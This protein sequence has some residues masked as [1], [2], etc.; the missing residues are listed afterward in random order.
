MRLLFLSLSCPAPPNNGSKMRTWALLR[1]LAEE[2]HSITLLAFAEPQEVDGNE[3]VVR[4]LCDRVEWVPR[5][6]VNVSAGRDYWARLKHM[7]SRAPHSAHGFRSRLMEQRIRD[8]LSTGGVDAIF[9]EQTQP[10]INV[11]GQL[12]VPLIL[13]YMSVEYLTWYRYMSCER[14]PVKKL[15]ARLE[16]Q[17]MRQWERQSCQRA[18]VAIACSEHDRAL[19]QSL[20]PEAR[21]LAVPNVVD[22]DA[23][24]PGGSENSLVV[25]YQGGMDWYPN[26]DAVAYFVESIL[27]ELRKLVPG[28]QF[29]VGGRNPSEE[30]RK[31]FARL[32][33][34]RFTGTVSD[35]GAVIASAAVCVVPL[36][37]GSGTRLK[38]LE[39]AAMAKPIVSTRL[40]AEGLDFLQDQEILLADAP[41]DFAH[42]VADLLH[43]SSRRTLLGRGARKR[44]EQQYSFPALLAAIR[45]VITESER[46]RLES[47]A[48]P[49]CD[50]VLGGRR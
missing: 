46:R 8:L 50:S 33:D 37:I 12:P 48:V 2:G 36:R 29:V 5:E 34:V 4:S 30:F 20:C 10:L 13:D 22:T 11:A 27:P 9:C 23:Y 44:V 3:P 49:S 42:A 7:F 14:N 26:R 18:T 16:S 39:A 6:Y 41:S 28:V 25:L 19:L 38:I 40:G 17:K 35:M 45:Q 15:Y 1:A 31:R 47:P 43:N 21:V 24:Q 32:A